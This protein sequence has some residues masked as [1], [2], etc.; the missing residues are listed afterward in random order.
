[1]AQPVHELANLLILEEPAHQLGARIFPF[2][3]AQMPRQ[4]HLR[5]DAQQ[6]RRHFEIVCRLIQPEVV[7]HRQEL[8]RDLRDRQIGDVDLVFPNQM[9]QQVERAGEFLQLDDEA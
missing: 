1:M 4:Q 6:S 5:L 7:D 2:V 9:E 8:I 3:V